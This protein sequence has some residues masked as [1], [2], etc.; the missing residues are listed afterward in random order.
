[1]SNTTPGEAVRAL[2][3]APDVETKRAAFW[4]CRSHGMLDGQLAPH[5]YDLA[6]DL[7]PQHLD[8][9]EECFRW[10]RSLALASGNAGLAAAA[11]NHLGILALDSGRAEIARTRFE[12]ARQGREAARPAPADDA[13]VYLAGTLCN[14][15]HAHCDVGDLDAAMQC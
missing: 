1:M 15:G 5:V 13:S 12:T 6:I 2:Q 8:E 3:T 10:A 7:K 9:A 11:A 4:R 14:L